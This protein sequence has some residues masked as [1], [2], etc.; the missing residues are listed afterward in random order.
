MKKELAFFMAYISNMSY[1]IYNYSNYHYMISY[2]VNIEKNE[3][4][5]AVTDADKN[6]KLGINSND[7]E[8]I[9]NWLIKIEKK[10]FN[11]YSKNY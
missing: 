3:F 6:V 10:F 9:K 5:L 2:S 11:F 8:F 7:T 1:R 4:F